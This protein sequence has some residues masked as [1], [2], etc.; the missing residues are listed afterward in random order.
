MKPNRPSASSAK[1]PWLVPPGIE[2]EQLVELEPESAFT[3]RFRDALI[4]RG[5]RQVHEFGSD[6]HTVWSSY[7]P[8]AEFLAD[9]K[10]FYARTPQQE[11]RRHVRPSAAAAPRSRSS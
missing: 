4:I 1:P 10:D 7:P 6:R 2:T 3:G 9:V 5:S 11:C 8:P